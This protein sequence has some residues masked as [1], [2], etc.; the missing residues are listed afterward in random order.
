[1]TQKVISYMKPPICKSVCKTKLLYYRYTNKEVI[2]YLEKN[3]ELN[4]FIRGN[5]ESLEE[6]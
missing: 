5:S 3:P 2:S 1:M 4:S 6:I